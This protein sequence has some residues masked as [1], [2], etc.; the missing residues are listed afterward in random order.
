MSLSLIAG[1]A[2]I[3]LNESYIAA[4]NKWQTFE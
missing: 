3:D 1:M 2:L 4:G